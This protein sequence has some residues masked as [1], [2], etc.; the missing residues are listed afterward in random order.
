TESVAATGKSALSPADTELIQTSTDS[1]QQI[2]V[3]NRVD[4]GSDSLTDIMVK[5]AAIVAAL[6][7]Y[8]EA[9]IHHFV[10]PQLFSA[11]YVQYLNATAP[12]LTGRVIEVGPNKEYTSLAL[13]RN[14]IKPGDTI[15]LTAGT[16]ALGPNRGR[17]A[18]RWADIAII[19]AGPELTTLT[20]QVESALR[21]R[22]QNLR[23]Q[24]DDDEFVDLRNGGSL[25]L[26]DCVISGYNSGAGGSNAVYGSGCI[27]L[28]ERCTFEGRSGRVADRHNGDALDL[29][30]FCFLYVRQSQFVDNQEIIRATFPCVF[31]ACTSRTTEDRRSHGIMPYPT[32]FVLLRDNQATLSSTQRTG[33]FVPATDD[34]EFLRLVL[35]APSHAGKVAQNMSERLALYRNLPYWIGLLR[36]ENADVRSAAADQIKKL[37]GQVVDLAADNQPDHDAAASLNPPLAAEASAT[38]MMQWYDA[39][40]DTLVWDE[41]AGAYRTS[42]TRES[43]PSPA[44]P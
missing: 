31:D 12:R 40:R 7:E 26:R 37:T 21:L 3:N 27:M 39:H 22:L 33:Q 32:G 14:A 43:E 18:T 41:A 5:R 19:G 13:A 38:R 24:C 17:D 36:H 28:V 30:G 1:L 20:G 34:L 23:L 2:L 10:D 8:Q 29:R 35:G 11:D 9:V 42:D 16:F 15:R 25:H 4:F 44:T 6:Q